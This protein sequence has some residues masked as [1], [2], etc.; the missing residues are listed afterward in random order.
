MQQAHNLGERIEIFF[1]R[2]TTFKEV[3]Q[4]TMLPRWSCYQS[5]I[6]K[7][8]RLI[9]M[10]LTWIS[11]Y[12][13]TCFKERILLSIDIKLHLFSSSQ[14]NLWNR[15]IIPVVTPPQVMTATSVDW[16]LGSAKIF[17]TVGPWFW[18]GGGFTRWFMVWFSSWLWFWGGE[19]FLAFHFATSWG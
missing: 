2:H 7:R 16:S 10:H 1:Q 13:V 12:S 8:W 9:N 19:T 5:W 6:K 17:A 15:A 14:S 3:L 18:L 4:G 11:S